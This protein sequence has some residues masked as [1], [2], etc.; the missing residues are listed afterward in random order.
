MG[1][2]KVSDPLVNNGK[3]KRRSL[4]FVK[5]K[6][7]NQVAPGSDKGEVPAR[8]GIFFLRFNWEKPRGDGR[9]RACQIY[10]RIKC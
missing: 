7:S 8:S 4:M 10:S 5:P 6:K 3:S 2:G 1:E 9:G